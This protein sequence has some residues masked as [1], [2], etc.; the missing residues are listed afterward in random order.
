M[1]YFAFKRSLRTHFKCQSLLC[2]F[3]ASSC[4]DFKFGLGI[5]VGI[6]TRSINK[7]LIRF[8]TSIFF[9]FTSDHQTFCNLFKVRCHWVNQS[10]HSCMLRAIYEVT[11]LHP[12]RIRQNAFVSH[13]NEP[14]SFRLWAV[15]SA[16]RPER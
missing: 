12:S 11:Q 7:V 8:P 2:C 10:W 3:T 15:Y 5:V 16:P 13:G 1:L 14:L 9:V 4:R 6:D